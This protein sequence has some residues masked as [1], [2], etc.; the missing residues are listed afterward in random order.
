MNRIVFGLLALVFL[1]W[2]LIMMVSSYGCTKPLLPHPLSQDMIEK[3]YEI[4]KI[5]GQEYIRSR[6][7]SI[8]PKKKADERGK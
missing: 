8:T 2:G 6:N 5:D 3:G 7:G 1:F 4:I